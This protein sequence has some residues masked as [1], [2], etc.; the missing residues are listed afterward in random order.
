MV[1]LDNPRHVTLTLSFGCSRYLSV[2]EGTQVTYIAGIWDW[3]L[4]DACCLAW[5]TLLICEVTW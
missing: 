5:L 2:G 1:R 4:L 3:R